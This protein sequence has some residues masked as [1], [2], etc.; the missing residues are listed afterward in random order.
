VEVAPAA[1]GPVAAGTVGT[2]V[3]RV[4]ARVGVAMAV[5][6]AAAAAVMEAAA[7]KEVA[8][9][10]AAAAA[11]MEV[12]EMAAVVTARV[13]AVTA[14]MAVAEK[15]EASQSVSKLGRRPCPPLPQKFRRRHRVWQRQFG[16]PAKQ[17]S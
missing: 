5:G 11:V 1:V 8:E 6:R 13:A 12:V 9:R 7:G 4:A 17:S 10:V 3:E 2:E 16:D 14:A 15:T